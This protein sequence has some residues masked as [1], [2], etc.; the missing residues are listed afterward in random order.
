VLHIPVWATHNNGDTVVPAAYTT[1]YVTNIN[2]PSPP[3]VSPTPLAIENLFQSNQHDAWDST[4]DPNWTPNGLNVYQWMLQYQRSIAVLPVTLSDYRVTIS[5]TNQVTVSW[6]TAFE[7]NNAYFTVQR[8]SDGVRFSPLATITATNQSN[9]SSYSYTDRNPLNGDNYYRLTQTDIDGR[10]TYFEI[11]KIS[12][13]RTTQSFIRVYPNP[14]TTDLSLEMNNGVRGKIEA[15]LIDQQ[16][17]IIRKIDFDKNEDHL[18]EEIKINSLKTGYY[19]IE[20]AGDNYST[21]LSFIK[22]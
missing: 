10:I 21:K 4:Y 7:Q 12:F 11:K 13:G 19:V 6:K 2:S 20:L 1:G 17:R 18:E 3:A 16:G 15:R 5:G 9:G 8:S 22:K 14:A